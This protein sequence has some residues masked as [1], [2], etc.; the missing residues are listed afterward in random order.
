MNRQ[1]TSWTRA[2]MVS[3]GIAIGQDN[4]PRHESAA[5]LEASAAETALQR[6]QQL[7]TSKETEVRVVIARRSDCPMGLLAALAFDHSPDVRTGVAGNP[8]ITGAVSDHL[9]KDRDP[10]VVKALARNHIIDIALLERLALHRKD[11]VRRVASRNLDERVHGADATTVTTAAVHLTPSAEQPQR[12]RM[13]AELQD[14]VAVSPLWNPVPEEDK[15]RSTAP[16]VRK[17]PRLATFV[18]R[19]AHR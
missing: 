15:A 19:Q 2:L 10:N 7:A 5:W 12:A 16:D 14:R 4:A 3:S 6:L 11:D 8:R 13:P 18:P 1:D 17:L 9:A